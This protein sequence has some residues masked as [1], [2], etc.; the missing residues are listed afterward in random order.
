MSARAVPHRDA[1]RPARRGEESDPVS[2]GQPMRAV[3][4]GALGQYRAQLIVAEAGVIDDRE[5]EPLHQFRIAIRRSRALLRKFGD[6]LDGSALTRFQSDFAWMAK[7][8]GRQ[9]DLDVLLERLDGERRPRLAREPEAALRAMIADRRRLARR[10]LLRVLSSARYRQ[11]KVEWFHFLDELRKPGV[12][13]APARE[14]A[15]ASLRSDWDELCR[16]SRRTG[17]RSRFSRLHALRKEGKELRYAIEAFTELFG[18]DAIAELTRPLRRLQDDLGDLCDRHVQVETLGEMLEEYRSSGA[19][20]P[21]AIALRQW[22]REIREQARSARQ[23]VAKRCRKFGRKRN[24]R[25]F[26]KIAEETAT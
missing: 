2:S 18:D 22:R 7:A 19:A 12:P 10:A 4:A 25:R 14:F 16:R 8:A 1:T 24:R 26:R 11:L 20:A 15:V 21:A 5:I 9:R 13:S 6:C 3:L 17:A 23:R